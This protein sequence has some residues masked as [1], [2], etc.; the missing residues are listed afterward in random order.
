MVS[1]SPE[2]L[3][4][5][6]WGS[7]RQGAAGFPWQPSSC[8]PAG[9]EL[10]IHRA[11]AHCSTP[12]CKVADFKA[13]LVVATSSLLC[14]HRQKPLCAG[15]HR[16]VTLRPASLFLCWRE[17]G[18]RG[19]KEEKK[20]VIAASRLSPPKTLLPKGCPSAR[21]PLPSVRTGNQTLGKLGW[22]EAATS[23][24]FVGNVNTGRLCQAV[25]KALS[26]GYFTC[27]FPPPTPP[28]VYGF[29][30]DK[31]TLTR[32]LLIRLLPFA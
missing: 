19:G 27:G 2:W 26:P 18:E 5:T 28:N 22:V 13:K 7:A 8:I 16:L 1:T 32:P 11:P 3:H 25:S 17:V 30:R 14:P 9:I 4:C 24:A 10:N 15:D 12:P 29:T 20:L 6:H 21:V 31:L 23:E